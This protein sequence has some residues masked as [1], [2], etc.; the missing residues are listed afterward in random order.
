MS[1][2]TIL[3]LDPAAVLAEGNIRHSLI[4][5]RVEVMK[6]SVVDLG[7]IQ[8]PVHVE[9]IEGAKKGQ[10]AYRLRKGFYRHAAVSAL[11]GQGAGLTLPAIVVEPVDA[12]TRL[13]LQIAENVDRTNLSP[14][15]TAVAIKR[16]LLEGM[17]RADVRNIFK[18]SGGRKGNA[19]QPASNSFLNIH[20]SMLDLPKS[21]QDKIHDGRVGVAAAYELTKVSPDKREAILARAE[22]MRAK[23]LEREEKE[24]EKLAKAEA[25]EGEA[26][27][28]L[29]EA[30]TALDAAEAEK[31]AAVEQ[32]TEAQTTL[33]EL[34]S[35]TVAEMEAKSADEKKVLA[36]SMLAA[37]AN[38]K[39]AERRV[40]KAHKDAGNARN[41]VSK[42]TRASEETETEAP[43]AKGAA[44]KPKA[45]AVGPKDVQKA[46][47]EAGE[48]K[49]HV[50]LN[51]NEMRQAVAALAKSRFPKAKAV[52]D[53]LAQCF[54][55]VTTPG[56][57]VTAIEV[58]TGER[59]VGKA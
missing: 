24:D 59:K 53:A 19:V 20:L 23:D 54:A 58:A 33:K 41:A 31:A 56:A 29:A 1:K 40:S 42:L 9:V 21:I 30:Q 25:K 57:M 5:A 7:G 34:Q 13:R 26:Q 18:R 12:L 32:L 8:E 27:S 17:D 43:K 28:K 50:A 38:I 2:Q 36:E 4:P 6:A 15:D 39:A 22:E 11:N 35:I 10:P 3:Q 51:A 45:K 49:K 16:L 14:I 37:K 44:G 46:A 48:G 55:G 47:K 52:A